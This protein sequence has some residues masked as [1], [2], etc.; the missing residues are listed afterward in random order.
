MI[1]RLPPIKIVTVIN[2]LKL[3]KTLN[4]TQSESNTIYQIKSMKINLDPL[5]NMKIRKIKNLIL[6]I[7]L[8][9]LIDQVQHLNATHLK[10]KTPLLKRVNNY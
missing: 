8:K 9:K 6:I 5:Q 1:I 10:N 2:F 7:I 3:F 4:N